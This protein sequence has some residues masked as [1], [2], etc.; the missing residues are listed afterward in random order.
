MSAP[1]KDGIR[2]SG[3]RVLTQ[4]LQPLAPQPLSRLFKSATFSL[5]LDQAQLK[6]LRK[7]SSFGLPSTG[8]LGGCD[9]S[10]PLSRSGFE[11]QPDGVSERGVRAASGFFFLDRPGP[12]L[13]T[14]ASTI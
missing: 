12:R 2:T 3:L 8:S 13:C 14:H 11:N 10:R 1:S 5:G 7:P 6:K 9:S 4:T